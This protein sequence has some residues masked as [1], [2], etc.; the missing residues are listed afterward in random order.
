MLKEKTM[1]RIHSPVW[2]EKH[3][4]CTKHNL[5]C[6]PYPQCLAEKDEDI[7]V[8]F[9]DIETDYAAWEGLNYADFFVMAK[10]G[11]LKG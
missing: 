8:M 10:H 7:L 6:I 9:S 3:G 5:P 11:L 2:D 4:I 1:P